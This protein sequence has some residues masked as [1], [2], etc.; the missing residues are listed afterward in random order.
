MSVENEVTQPQFCCKTESGY[1]ESGRTAGQGPL[2]V[3]TVHC[4]E[5]CGIGCNKCTM[6]NV[7]CTVVVSREQQ[8]VRIVDC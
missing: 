7:Q 4:T 1:S 6:Y 5:H 3:C 8:A 2:S